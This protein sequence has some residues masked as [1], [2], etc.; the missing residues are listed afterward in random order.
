M[1]SI[2]IAKKLL[3]IILLIFMPPSLSLIIEIDG[4]SHD[5]KKEYDFRREGFF[6]SFGLTVFKIPDIE[7]KKNLSWV[8]NGL[9]DFIIAEYG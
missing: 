8:M 4:S 7:V 2:L 3:A 9:K 5:Y 1:E 6:K